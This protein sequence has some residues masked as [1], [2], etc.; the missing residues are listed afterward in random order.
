MMK[1]S[2][3]KIQE[4]MLIAKKIIF[5]KPI[6][7]DDFPE[8]GMTAWLTKISREDD[9]WK[10]FFDFTDFEEE[11][12]K[13]LTECYYSNIHTAK[14]QTK[15]LYTAKES[16]NYSNKYSVLF[17]DCD[18]IKYGSFEDQISEYLMVVK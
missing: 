8:R 2:D 6:F 16:G 14:L 5:K 4:D 15:E 9:Y 1:T 12:D 10:L 7:E 13:Y 3:N 11:N 17:G 18:I